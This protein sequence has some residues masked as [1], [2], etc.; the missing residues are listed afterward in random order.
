MK[1][2]FEKGITFERGHIFPRR[3][4]NLQNLPHWHREH[5]LVLVE[6]GTATIMADGIFFTLQAGGGAFL[7]SEAIHSIRAEQGA[8]LTVAKID[9]AHFRPLLGDRVPESPV[10]TE[11]HSVGDALADL[12]AELAAPDSY[13]GAVADAIATRLLAE[14]L[15]RE[16]L[17]ERKGE[18]DTAERYKALMDLI[19]RDYADL[20]FD[21]AARFMHFSKPYFSKFFYAHT[22]MTFTQYLNTIRISFAAERLSAGDATVTE[23]SQSCGFNTIRNFNRVFKALTGYTPATLP[24]GYTFIR[25]IRDYADTGFDPTLGCTE[26]LE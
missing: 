23:V 9:A 19:H 24:R 17:T 20:T 8:V 22:G 7:H 13:S 15:R 26:V 2:Q 6:A 10:L 4:R 5:E 12:Q 14:M 11:G 1:T 3:Y 21:E 18:S 16:V 25:N